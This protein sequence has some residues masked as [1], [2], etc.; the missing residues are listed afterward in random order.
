MPNLRVTPDTLR[1][2][3]DQ[4]DL[5]GG[6]ILHHLDEL[7]TYVARLEPHWG[8]AAAVRFHDMMK[9]WD[10]LAN[11]LKDALHGTAQGIRYDA[12]HYSETE[13][14]A[15][16]RVTNLADNLPSA[17]STTPLRPSRF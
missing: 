7:R 6:E 14:S 5:R 8:G 1:A 11:N 2:G 9:R 15:S 16:T 12:D 4:C 10:L 17:G 13:H 3:A